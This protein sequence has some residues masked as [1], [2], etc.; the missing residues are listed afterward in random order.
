MPSMVRL[1]DS[2]LGKSGISSQGVSETQSTFEPLLKQARRTFLLRQPDAQDFAERVSR[3]IVSRISLAIGESNASAINSNG[4][5]PLAVTTSSSI[6]GSKSKDSSIAEMLSQREIHMTAAKRYGALV[7]SACANF[8]SGVALTL[9]TNGATRE[10]EI[11]KSDIMLALLG[12]DAKATFELQKADLEELKAQA[13]QQESERAQELRT[14][15]G[16]LNEERETI[17]QRIFELKQSIEKLEAYDAELCV[18]VGDAQKERDDEAAL[19]SAE[20]LSLNDKIKEA[21]DAIKYGNSVLDVVNTLKKYDDSLDKAIQASSKALSIPA[22]DV[23][24]YAQQQMEVYLSRVRSYFQS[25]ANTVDFLRTR[26]EASTKAVADLVGYLSVDW[27]VTMCI[28]RVTNSRSPCLFAS[29][30]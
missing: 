16:E 25:E 22:A 3:F 7:R 20:A 15:I 24:D 27:I 2:L 12:E 19:A 10:T 17:K 13:K 9:S 8:N 14:S 30:N 6:S 5:A 26:I 28:C 23:A 11:A 21:S 4:N 18:K 29:E 1:M